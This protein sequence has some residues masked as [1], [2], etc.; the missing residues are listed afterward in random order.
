MTRSLSIHATYRC[1]RTG[2]CCTSNWP[3]PIEADRLARLRVAL[4]SGAL[5]PST[6]VPDCFHAPPDAPPDTPALLATVDHRCVFF[7]AAA[8]RR[9]RVHEALGHDALP[10]ACRQFPRVV[11]RDSRG[12]SIVLSHYCPTAA[13]MLDLDAAVTIVESPPAFPIAGEYEGLDVRGAFPPLL[14]PGV[15]MDWDSWWDFERCA[16]EFLGNSGD[17][18]TATLARLA[19]IVDHVR[20]WQPGNGTLDDRIQSA[21]AGDQAIISDPR[22]IDSADARAAEVIAA[23][24]SELNAP[25]VARPNESGSPRVRA[26]HRFLAAHAFANWTAHLGLGLRTWLRSIDAAD[27]LL[28]TGRTFR[29]TDLILRHLADPKILA[30]RW[31]AGERAGTIRRPA[32]FPRADRAIR[33]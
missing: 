31:S 8:G 13:A 17:T 2:A 18:A 27:A 21:F 7:D 26:V 10:L 29:E 12:V 6:E 24:P 9:C 28:R 30:E 23:I 20:E 16:V 5:R 19:R 1:Q 15:L 11:V 3:I 25:D 33:S 22:A 4:A 14:R 32:R